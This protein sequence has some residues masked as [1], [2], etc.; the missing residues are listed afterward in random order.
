[1]LPPMSPRARLNETPDAESAVRAR[2]RQA[3]R[4]KAFA[5]LLL[6]LGFGVRCDGC[7]RDPIEPKAAPSS[8]AR[9]SVVTDA[10]RITSTAG[11]TPSMQGEG[12]PL[13]KPGGGIELVG[14]RGEVVAFQVVVS[15]GTAPLNKIQVEINDVSGPGEL[16]AKDFQRFILHELPFHRRSGGKTAGESL[17]WEKQATPAAPESGTSI[18]DPL[19]PVEIAPTWDPY[20]LEIEA[21][22]QRVIWIDVDLTGSNITPGRYSAKLVV[23]SD[24]ATLADIP[25]NLRVGAQQLPYAAAK[26]MLYFEPDKVEERVGTSAA[27]DQ[28]LQL[29]HAHHVS[30]VLPLNSLRE[31]EAAKG[32]LD[33]SLFTAAAGYHGAGAG[34]GSS[35]VALGAYGMLRDPSAA[36]LKLVGQMLSRLEQLGVKDQ[37]GERDVFL[38]AVDEQCESPRGKDWRAALDKSGVESLRQLRVGHTC[39]DPPRT[40]AVDLVIMFSS[41][42]SESAQAEARKLGKHIWIYN[43]VLPQTGSFLTD[44]WPVSLRANAWI[45]ARYGIERWFY[46]ESTFWHDGNPG[47]K[48]PYDPFASAETFHN[49]HGDHCNGDG[50]LVY[51]GR[52]EPFQAHDLGFDG[53][54]PSFRLK[55]W[56]RGIQDAGYIQLA[57]EKHPKQTEAILEERIPDALKG[58]SGDKLPRWET[59]GKGWEQARR[60][61]F[62]LVTTP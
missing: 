15:A 19:I 37:P 44:A 46:W 9:V 33:G 39:S 3:Q 42:Y 2:P 48:G 35:V 43:G 56:R 52:Q 11:V 45:Q 7:Q 20:P 12:N 30:S 40:Q 32:L 57:R 13:W 26:T 27:T 31:L 17:G 16:T 61:L 28:Y 50:V 58:L 60:E 6:S 23:R 54:L 59:S 29:L 36:K 25:L 10:E 21:R 47:G 4:L 38:Y 49:Q 24:A 22:R 5:V 41:E 62:E 14:L 18:P 8:E 1:M 53:V 51:P 55:Q 34:E